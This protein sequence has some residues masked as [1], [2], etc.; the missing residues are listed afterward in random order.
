MAGVVV[1]RSRVG[2]EEVDRPISG[3]SLELRR[4]DD[5]ERLAQRRRPDSLDHGKTTRDQKR[6]IDDDDDGDG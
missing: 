1:G 3:G 2:R 6:Q 4:V 5:D